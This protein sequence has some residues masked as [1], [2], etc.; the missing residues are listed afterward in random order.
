MARAG[1][2]LPVTDAIVE[3][4]G[5]VCRRLN[6]DV[7]LVV[8]THS[9]RTA[10][11]ASKQ[12]HAT[13]TLALTD[14]VEIAQAMGLYWGVTALHIPELF[15]TGQVLSW[16]DEWCRANDLIDSGDRVVIV[17]TASSPTIPTTTPCWCT[18]WNDSLQPRERK[19][20]EPLPGSLPRTLAAGR[21]RRCLDRHRCRRRAA[22]SR[23]GRGQPRSQDLL[24]VQGAPSLDPDAAD[25][26]DSMSAS[27]RPPARRSGC[28]PSGPAAI[29]PFPGLRFIAFG[30]LHRFRMSLSRPVANFAPGDVALAGNSYL[31]VRGFFVFRI[32]RLV[33]GAALIDAG[34]LGRLC[35]KECLRYRGA[36]CR[37]WHFLAQH[38][39]RSCHAA[40]EKQISYA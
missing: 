32:F 40:N 18:K 12:R 19:L 35:L 28:Q 14:D 20:G 34:I 21:N 38:H 31:G 13:P 30:I 3:A 29:E 25:A 11:A 17:P 15:E 10:L 23:P 16:A 1:Q 24:R 6:A 27:R 7:F 9:G 5:A 22:G 39:A 4:A 2:V 8:A 37:F 26:I 33:A 36:S